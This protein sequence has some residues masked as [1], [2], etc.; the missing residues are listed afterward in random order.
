M[1]RPIQNAALSPGPSGPKNRGRTLAAASLTERLICGY[2]DKTLM[3]YSTRVNFRGNKT[4][5]NSF[6]LFH[7]SLALSSYTLDYVATCRHCAITNQAARLWLSRLSQLSRRRRRPA[8]CLSVSLRYHSDTKHSAVVPRRHDIDTGNGQSR[9]RA[10]V[11]AYT[12]CTAARQ[13]LYTNTT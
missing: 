6:I 8:F 10:E 2:V 12:L 4:T 1:R 3:L 11:V 7:F 5:R 9:M 13:A